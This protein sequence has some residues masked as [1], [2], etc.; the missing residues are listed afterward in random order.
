MIESNENHDEEHSYTYIIE[1][2]VRTMDLCHYSHDL[3]AEQKSLDL[4]SRKGPSASRRCTAN[5]KHKLRLQLRE[6]LR[7]KPR[8]RHPA[9]QGPLKDER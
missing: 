8:G 7:V 6:S 5:L 3:S 9:A 4:L 2:E 1:K